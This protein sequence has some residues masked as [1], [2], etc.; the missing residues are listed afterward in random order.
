MFKPTT[1]IVDDLKK[2]EPIA[3]TLDV[4][5]ALL[6]PL[7]V[8]KQQAKFMRENMPQVNEKRRVNYYKL[9]DPELRPN[10]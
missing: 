3:S 8:D 7:T 9:A 5:S 10:L 6:D 1:S 4:N 2:T